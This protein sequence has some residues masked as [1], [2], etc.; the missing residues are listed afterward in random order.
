MRG[1]ASFEKIWQEIIEANFP[2]PQL[3]KENQL[4]HI[5]KYVEEKVDK[6]RK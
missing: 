2:K 4:G 3:G 5:E 6:M 1:N